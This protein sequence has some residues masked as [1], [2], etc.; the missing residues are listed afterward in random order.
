MRCF[1]DRRIP[2]YAT[3]LAWAVIFFV[4]GCRTSRVPIPACPK[5]V[6]KSDFLENPL[7]YRRITVLPVQVVASLETGVKSPEHPAGK[8]WGMFVSGMKQAPNADV[9]EWVD[10]AH[11]DPAAYREKLCCIKAWKDYYEQ[12]ERG[13]NEVWSKIPTN[14]C[15][16]LVSELAGKGYEAVNTPEAVR[17]GWDSMTNDA[18]DRLVRGAAFGTAAARGRAAQMWIQA[19]HGK[20]PNV[21]SVIEVDQVLTNSVAELLPASASD[22]D[23]IILC[24]LMVQ[25]ESDQAVSRREAKDSRAMAWHRSQ[26]AMG[27]LGAVIG[28]DRSGIAPVRPM[29]DIPMNFVSHHLWL[30]DRRSRRLLWEG[31]GASGDIREAGALEQSLRQALA[32]LPMQ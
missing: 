19:L 17:R 2:L 11:N 5:V 29:K 13:E 21:P 15:S 9:Q 12:K 32:G 7:A 1:G 27:V 23:A 25:I 14:V 26:Q 4:A 24:T 22:S 31:D 16:V 18:L 6:I 10:L 28:S 8:D 3:L 30:I 20:E